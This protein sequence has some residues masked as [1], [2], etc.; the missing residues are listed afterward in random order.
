MNASP[1]EACMPGI[2]L[3]TAPAAVLPKQASVTAFSFFTDGSH[4]SNYYGFRIPFIKGECEMSRHRAMLIVFATAVILALIASSGVSAQRPG[5]RGTPVVPAGAGELLSEVTNQLPNAADLQATAQA[6]TTWSDLLNAIPTEIPDLESL[7]LSQ[8]P[9]AYSMDDLEAL[10]N[11]LLVSS[12]EAYAALVGFAAESLGT[13]VAPIYAGDAT[14]TIEMTASQLA[15]EATAAAMQQI[16]GQFP[17]ETQAMIAQAASISGNAYWGVLSN[18]AAVLYTD[19]CKDNPN[20]AINLDV[21]QVQVSNSSL[22]AYA[23]YVPSGAQSS[24]EAINL[25]KA[26]FPALAGMDFLPIPGVNDYYAFMAE[27]YNYG[28]QGVASGRVVYAGVVSYVGQSLVYAVVV[29][30]E[31]YLSVVSIF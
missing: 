18:G 19:A 15:N 23:V 5:L 9:F 24:A 28:A 17:P 20:C 1:P 14:A 31:G 21:L 11:E 29:T 10:L 26:A 27:N 6:I 7:D 8:I 22:G 30:G 4:K 3:M 2:R 12:P 25:I 16:L 13:A